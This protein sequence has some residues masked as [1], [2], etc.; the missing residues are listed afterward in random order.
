MDRRPPFAE[1]AV[2]RHAEQQPAEGAEQG[3]H[4]RDAAE[5]HAVG[6]QGRL[7]Q[8][9]V[10][11]ASLVA[12][13]D[14]EQDRASREQRERPGWPAVGLALDERVDD[15][16]ERQADEPDAADVEL[17]AGVT[18]PARQRSDRE[19]Q[20]GEADR[21]VDEE[22]QSPADVP[23]I[24]IDECPGE[25]RRAEHGQTGR[26][27]EQASCPAQFLVVE[28]FL[29]QAEALRDHQ[30]A[31]ASLQGAEGDQHADVRRDGTR[32]REDGEPEQ[33]EQEHPATAED[34]SQ[35]RPRDQEDGK[36]QR[37]GSAQPLDRAG[38]SAEFAVNRG[39]GDVHDRRVEQI[40]GVGGQHH[41]RHDPAQAV[42]L[43]SGG[44]RCGGEGGVH[45]GFLMR[46]SS[47]RSARLGL[48]NSVRNEHCS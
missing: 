6:E 41:G 20:R 26:R 46:S 35:P 3:Q 12:H 47:G 15:R 45:D 14:V 30:R 4:D 18:D 11:A 31:E 5:V 32:G 36:G 9:V 23:E 42:G 8:G 40:H 33:A 17:E 44:R 34:V 13:E 10:A 21:H 37:V 2:Q 22:D 25:D 19:R 39:A 43:R 7:D 1:L 28:D 29:Q 24:G 27:A 48:T 38:T 16:H